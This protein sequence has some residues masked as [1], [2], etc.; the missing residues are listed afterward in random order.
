ALKNPK[1]W[2]AAASQ[3]FFS[4]SVG[5]GVILNYASYLRENDDVVLSGLTSAATN[6]VFEVSFGGLITIP[7]A[8]LFL[9]AGIAVGTFSL[10]FM[11]LPVVFQHMGAAGR[12][13]GFLFFFLLFLAAITS[14]ISM[15]QPVKAFL[16]EALDV[17]PKRSMAL[18]TVVTLAGSLFIIYFS[19]DLIAL[20][21]IDFWIGTLGIFLLATV[22]AVVF[23]WV[24]GVD[25][26]L[27]EAH[28]GA[29]MRIPGFFRFV[30]KY[31]TPVYLLGVLGLFCYYSLGPY[32]ST[33]AKSKVAI[34]SVGV[35]GVLLVLLLLVLR[36]GEKR[37]RRL[38]YDL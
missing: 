35:I 3:I 23:A 30:M 34:A 28:R 32:L 20:D 9:G 27:D 38:G 11:T 12:I 10:G 13:F 22:Q 18:F 31:V 15:F 33:L 7:A 37:W 36:E 26:G 16:E 17:T 2:M 1:T 5:F 6:E 8:Y 25:R 4:L 19:K 14:S 21:T 24:F 29:L